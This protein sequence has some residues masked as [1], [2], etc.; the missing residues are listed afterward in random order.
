MEWQVIPDMEVLYFPLIQDTVVQE[1]QHLL[2]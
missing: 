1:H 2:I